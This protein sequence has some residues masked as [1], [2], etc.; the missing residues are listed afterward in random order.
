MSE[1]LRLLKPFFRGLPIIIASVV[2]SALFAKKYLNYVTPMY[3][4][5]AKLELAD[6]QEGVPSTKLYKDFDVFASANKIATE[7]EVLKSSNLIQKT[8]DEL[9]FNKEIYR[10]GK[11]RTS[12][13][14]MDCP[15]SING[16][17]NS[18]KAYDQRYSLKVIST[19]NFLFS[20]PKSDS[21]IKGEFGIPLKIKGGILYITIN[22]NVVNSKK[23]GKLIDNFEFEFLSQ[24]K[25]MAKINKDL[26]IVAVD[27]DVPVVRINLKSNVPEKAALF[28]NKLAEMYIKDYIEIKYKAASI[29]VSFLKNEINSARDKLSSSEDNIQNYRDDKNIINFTQ[30]NETDLRKISQLKIQKTNVKMSLDAIKNLNKYIDKGKNHYLDLAANFEAFNDLLSTEMM[31]SIKKLQADKKDL[32][33]VY[34]P[35]NDKI[36]VID[37]KIKDLTDYQIE[38]IKNTEKDLQ[39]KY[40][41]LTA[42]IKDAE[43]V[44]IGLPE[45]E[46]NLKILEREFNLYERNYNYL[47]EKRIEAEIA[48][49]AKIAFHKV[50]SPATVSSEPVSPIKI[51]IILIAC[52]LGLIGSISI[53]YIYHSL[54]AKVN[55]V[56]TIEKNSTIPIAFTTPFVKKRENILNVFLKEVIQLELKGIIQKQNILVVSSYDKSKDHLFHS[57]NL[58]KAL[59]AQGRKVL[60]VDAAGELEGNIPTSDYINYSDNKYLSY[61]KAIF[62]EEI[63]AKLKDYDLCLIHNQSIKEDKLGLLFMSIA[64]QNL[65]ILDSRKTAEK[66]IVSIELLRD[67]YKLPNFWFVLNKD[68]YNPSL[69]SEIRQTWKKYRKRKSA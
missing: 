60:V 14:F 23:G 69:Y 3:E 64:S 51:I 1:N 62:Q 15:I 33:L 56:F 19:K 12:E 54:K 24:E 30:E 65:M 67:E 37:Q 34:T 2:L 28:V 41:K 8:L 36:K 7:I 21:K 53:I 6:V 29:T 5:S 50:I 38:S 31:K 61:T 25:L 27:K 44:F 35:E 47:N 40:D 58:T 55:D 49:S 10:K 22:Q 13:I 9:P 18:P 43:K 20:Y 66:A 16:T 17:F 63:K 11:L 59:V 48:R 42:D 39:I 46:K 57:I 32:L 52:V 26:D 68:D 4:S 45:R